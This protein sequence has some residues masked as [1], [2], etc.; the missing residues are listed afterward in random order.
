[1]QCPLQR[2]PI[3]QPPVRYIPG[4]STRPLPSGQGHNSRVKDK[5]SYGKAKNTTAHFHSITGSG[6]LMYSE[7]MWSKIFSL[8]SKSTVANNQRSVSIVSWLI[9]YTNIRIH[10]PSS[11][12]HHI[13]PKLTK[14]LHELDESLPLLMRPSI[15]D[16]ISEIMQNKS[17]VT[18][19]V[20]YS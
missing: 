18:R 17:V 5:V 4:M 7:L 6:Q 19:P 2:N 14:F 15:I 12:S 8:H 16:S 20:S 1:M 11:S 3:T 13:R 9:I 10:H